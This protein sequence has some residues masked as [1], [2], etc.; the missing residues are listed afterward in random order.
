MT[1]AI[2]CL[3]NL[4]LATCC[5]HISIMVTKKEKSLYSSADQWNCPL[6]PYLQKKGTNMMF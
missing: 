4:H 2:T 6:S 3:N 1:F 5:K